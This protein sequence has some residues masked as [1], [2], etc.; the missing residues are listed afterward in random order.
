MKIMM[1]SQMK[2]TQGG[3]SFPEEWK[4]CIPETKPRP[5]FLARG[6]RGKRT[7]FTSEDEKLPPVPDGSPGLQ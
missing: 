7:P 6:F 3:E 2:K 5:S 1:K 4:G